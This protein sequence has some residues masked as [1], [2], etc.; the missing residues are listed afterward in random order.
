VN[1]DSRGQFI[2]GNTAGK[3][4]PSRAIELDYLRTLSDTI[5]VNDWRDICAKAV[6]DAKSG[7][8]KAREWITRYVMGNDTT[9]SLMDIAIRDAMNITSEMD[10]QGKIEYLTLGHT[11]RI[12]ADLEGT[13]DIQRAQKITIN[14]DDMFED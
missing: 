13:N 14:M 9:T 6:E 10:I 11:D 7:N 4:R 3:G 12:M 1:R 5:T 8:A 2:K